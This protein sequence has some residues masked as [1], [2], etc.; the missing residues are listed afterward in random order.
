MIRQINIR[1]LDGVPKNFSIFFMKK[2][3]CVLLLFMPLE[4][5]Y[6][7]IKILYIFL[8]YR[9]LKLFLRK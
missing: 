4:K 5:I 1:F 6:T 2:F 7:K 3:K 8:D 9:H